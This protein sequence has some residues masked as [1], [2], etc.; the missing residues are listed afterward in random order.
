MLCWASMCPSFVSEYTF[1]YAR[2]LVF[3]LKVHDSDAYPFHEAICTVIMHC[4]L[5]T[6][7]IILSVI[8]GWTDA[9]TRA[10]NNSPE[11]CTRPYDT[12]T[13][14][15]AHDSPYLRDESTQF[16]SFGNQFFRTTTQLDAGVRL[17]S[18]Q[19][20]VASNQQT[21]KRELHVC[22]SSCAL[23]DAGPLRNWLHEIRM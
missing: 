22:H 1:L 2:A 6:S 10:C 19:V 5:L 13:Y 8:V 17:L 3:D 20:H 4:P 9:N 21:G 16:S 15:G 7:F 14:L 23:F 12:I 18:A 11:L